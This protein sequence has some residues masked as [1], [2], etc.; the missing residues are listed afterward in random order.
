MIL[1]AEVG[2]TV[3]ERNDWTAIHQFLITTQDDPLYPAL[4]MAIMSG[5]RRGELVGARWSDVDLDTGVW[6]VRR[7]LAQVKTF[8]STKDGPKTQ[9]ISQEPK[10]DK[11]RRTIS[12]APEVIDALRRHKALQAQEK[13]LIGQAYDDHDLIFCNPD[14]TPVN[15]RRLLRQFQRRLQ[16]AGLP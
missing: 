7:A 10:S 15:P 6:R 13:L 5:Y 2:F 1:A 11:S 8:N 9:L 16:H 4:L 3:G 12:L 14:G